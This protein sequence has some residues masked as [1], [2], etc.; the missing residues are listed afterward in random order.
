M[1]KKDVALL[2]GV[3]LK[4]VRSTHDRKA[5]ADI[6]YRV[7]NPFEAE[8]RIDSGGRFDDLKTASRMFRMRLSDR[9][10]ER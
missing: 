7:W 5:S 10:Q 3:N 2:D 9:R 1:V 4:R 6:G 8:L